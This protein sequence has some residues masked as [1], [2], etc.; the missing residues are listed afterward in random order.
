M[1]WKPQVIVY[2]DDLVVLHRD[3]DVIAH[4]QRLTADGLAGIGLELSPRKTRIA[5]TLQP[6]GGEAGFHFLGFV[7]H[8]RCIHGCYG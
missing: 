5:H 1:N 2:A 4:C 3:K 6:E 7:R 8:V